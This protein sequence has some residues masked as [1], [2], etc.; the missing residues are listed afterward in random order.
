MTANSPYSGGS[1]DEIVR[2]MLG[3][4][5]K[6][7]ASFAIDEPELQQALNR[8]LVNNPRWRASVTDLRNAL[9][10]WI[11]QR[12]EADRLLDD[13]DETEATLVIPSPLS[14]D[15]VASRMSIPPMALHDEEGL[16]PP[17]SIIPPA[18][19]PFFPRDSEPSIRVPGTPPPQ[20]FTPPES[21]GTPGAPVSS[22]P[23][24]HRPPPRPDSPVSTRPVSSLPLSTAAEVDEGDPLLGPT[25]KRGGW[26]RQLPKVLAA[27]SVF[28]MG[29]LGFAL[30]SSIGSRNA[31]KA[32]AGSRAV[33][34][35][36]VPH[37]KGAKPPQPKA[38]APASSAQQATATATGFSSEQRAACVN[39]LL[40]ED[41]LAPEQ[42]VDFLCDDRDLRRLTLELQGRL[43]RSSKGRA[44]GALRQWVGLG[45]YQLG[46]TAVVRQRCCPGKD[47]SIHL[48][49]QLGECDQLQAAVEQLVAAP[50]QVDEVAGRVQTFHSQ[51]LCLYAKGVPRPYPFKVA[52][53]GYNRRAFTSFFESAIKFEPV[54]P[55]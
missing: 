41:A 1:R 17:S 25:E 12:P 44:T 40:A 27:A 11:L 32:P 36:T 47:T 5:P 26:Q 50:L 7:L 29:G 6:P 8:G 28:V 31:A 53:T 14:G 46:V 2:N 10:R 42:T 39:G 33:V 4:E 22:V 34:T 35:T 15:S 30:F 48:P 52:P 20:T 19:E 38:S 54:A 43:I 16:H 18:S 51:L 9:E 21:Q 45:W 13:E 49:T 3:G 23:S 37:L 55:R 24:P